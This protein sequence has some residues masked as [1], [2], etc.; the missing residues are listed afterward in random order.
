MGFLR[1]QAR[2][3][4]WAAWLLSRLPDD[5]TAAA[6]DPG[7]A[8]AHRAD[9]RSGEYSRADRPR[10]RAA[11]TAWRGAEAARMRA[12]RLARDVGTLV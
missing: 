10:T 12:H 8:W 2:P 1:V 9:G 11:R 3:V 7:L 4:W 5:S 6:L